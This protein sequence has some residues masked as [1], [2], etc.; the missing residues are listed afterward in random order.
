MEPRVRRPTTV[1]GAITDIAAAETGLPEETFV[2]IGYMDVIATALA[3]GASGSGAESS[4][5]G[6]TL[7]TQVLTRRPTIEGPPVGLHA[8]TRSRR[9]ET[10]RDG[11]DGRHGEYRVGPRR[12]SDQFV[13]REQKKRARAAP[14]GSEGLIYHHYLSEAGEK[15]PF[16]DPNA[17]AQ[18][19][20]LT[21]D[22]GRAH[23]LRSVYEGVH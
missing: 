19:V 17:C 14:P 23:L 3:S 2:V 21:P 6:T 10:P 18:F 16:V 13:L 4:I 5:V 11:S 15:A 8:R 22:H 12:A 7:Q 9:S 20:G 1:A